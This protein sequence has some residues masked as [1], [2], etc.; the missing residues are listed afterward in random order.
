MPNIRWAEE[1]GALEDKIIM[2]N[3]KP[4]R[5]TTYSIDFGEKAGTARVTVLDPCITPEAQT[6]RREA[7]LAKC[8]ELIRRGE[9]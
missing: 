4:Y 3:G 9:M 7:I 5:V 8:R 1:V 2:E 6:K